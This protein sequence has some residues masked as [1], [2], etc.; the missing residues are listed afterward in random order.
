MEALGVVAQ[1]RPGIMCEQA[2]V[3]LRE[4]GPEHVDGRCVGRRLGILDGRELEGAEELRLGRTLFG[5]R[6]Q[7]RLLEPFEARLVAVDELDL[8]LSEA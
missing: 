8:E 1:A 2:L 3:L 7:E 6:F 4:R 5:T